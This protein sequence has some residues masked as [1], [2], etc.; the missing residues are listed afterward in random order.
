MVVSGFRHLSDA[1]SDMLMTLLELWSESLARMGESVRPMFLLLISPDRCCLFWPLPPP[2]GCTTPFAA[3][4]TAVA[5]CGAAAANEQS[6]TSAFA[7]THAHTVSRSRT[8][9]CATCCISYGIKAA[10]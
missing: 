9:H 6:S 8:Q 3:G 5:G 1:L 10:E 7:C 4:W 2:T